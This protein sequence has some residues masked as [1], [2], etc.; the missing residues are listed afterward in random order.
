MVDTKSVNLLDLTDYP[1][2]TVHTLSKYLVAKTPASGSAT[3]LTS[4]TPI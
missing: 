2:I 4:K 1:N 3:P